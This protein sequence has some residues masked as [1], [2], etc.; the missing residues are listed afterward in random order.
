[1]NLHSKE[2]L[3]FYFRVMAVLVV[4]CRHALINKYFSQVFASQ[5]LPCDLCLGMEK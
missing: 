4:R 1:M 5:A 2:I 3:V